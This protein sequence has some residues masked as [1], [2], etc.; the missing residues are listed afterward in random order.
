M[1]TFVLRVPAGQKRRVLSRD[2]RAEDGRQAQPQRYHDALEEV[3]RRSRFC[4]VVELWTTHSQIRGKPRALGPATFARLG[5]LIPSGVARYR[6]GAPP[7]GQS[8]A[9]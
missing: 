7:G 2:I 3:I 1:W 4:I 9:S 5:N 6:L 8:S